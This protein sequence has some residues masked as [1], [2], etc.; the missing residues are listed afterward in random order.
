MNIHRPAAINTAKILEVVMP[1]ETTAV[2]KLEAVVTTE[3]EINPPLATGIL[4]TGILVTARAAQVITG[5]ITTI[6][7]SKKD[8]RRVLISDI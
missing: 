6:E 8:T 1:E 3:A 5:Q 7:I 4:A 2:T